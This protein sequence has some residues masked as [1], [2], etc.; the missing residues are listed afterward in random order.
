[1]SQRRIAVVT[2]TR[3]D[4]GLLKPVLGT[5]EAQAGLELAVV[6]TGMHLLRRFGYTVREVAGDGWPIGGRVKL[7]TAADD[8][9]AQ[10]RGLGRAITG[11]TEVFSRLRTE[12]V[13]VLGDRIEAFAAAAAATAS[14]LVLAHIHGGEAALGVQDDAYRHAISKLAH[15]HFVASAGARRRL[16]RMGE[17]PW[18]IHRTGSP[19]LDNLVDGMCDD[20]GK[21]SEWAGFDVGDDFVVVLQ[22][23][24]G[25]SARQEQRWMAQTLAGCGRAGLKVLVLGPNSDPGFSGIAAAIEQVSRKRG[26]RT[27]VHVPREVYVGLLKRAR[28][29]VG[30]SSSGIIEAGYLGVNVVNVGPRQTGRERGRNVIDVPYGAEAVAGALKLVMERSG[31]AKRRRCTIYGDGHSSGRI[32]E[33]LAQVELNGRVRR[34]HTTPCSPGDY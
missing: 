12:V 6:V 18:R 29:L 30:N 15:V 3:A 9:V 25:G 5:I 2:G 13:L 11:L 27:L 16:G 22:H 4:Y 21:L 19:G 34:K 32:A 7:Q 14:Q 31:R 8:A 26:Y 20:A 28:A 33:I 23:P 17:E 24:A 1:M 10:S